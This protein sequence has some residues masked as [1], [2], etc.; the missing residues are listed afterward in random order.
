MAQENLAYIAEHKKER[1]E[2]H[3]CEDFGCSSVEPL[4][5][6]IV[7]LVEQLQSQQEWIDRVA[8]FSTD[9]AIA[10]DKAEEERD[11]LKE[12]FEAMREALID[13]SHASENPDAAPGHFGFLARRALGVS[14]PASRQEETR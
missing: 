6:G 13:I 8:E 1:G 12:Q 9:A 5:E 10:A 11:G 3:F 14:D 2:E 7:G 4:C